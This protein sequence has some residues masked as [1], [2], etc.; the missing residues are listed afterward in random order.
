MRSQVQILLAQLGVV[1]KVAGVGE[2][3][4]MVDGSPAWQVIGFFGS[5]AKDTIPK[6]LDAAVLNPSGTWVALSSLADSASD[7]DEG[8]SMM[9]SDFRRGT[10][11]ATR[12]DP[13]L[14]EPGSVLYLEDG[15]LELLSVWEAE[16]RMKAFVQQQRASGRTA[17]DRGDTVGALEFFD[18]ARRVSNEPEDIKAVATLE[19][20]PEMQRFF[21]AAL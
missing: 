9:Y 11:N 7:F 1:V 2:S 5:P 10:E 13:F 18:R 20:D 4:T 14:W 19:P 21:R 15:V 6:L 17:L 12:L 3:L 16:V 8:W